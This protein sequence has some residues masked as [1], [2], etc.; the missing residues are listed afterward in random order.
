MKK[1]KYVKLKDVQE[2]LSLIEA[3]DSFEWWS[4]PYISYD[5]EI[6]DAI[7]CLESNAKEIMLGIDLCQGAVI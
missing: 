3:R 1:E 2:I 5:K 7:V 6:K 4:Q